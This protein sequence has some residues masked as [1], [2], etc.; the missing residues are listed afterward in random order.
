ME[1]L[2]TYDKFQGD[3]LARFLHKMAD[4]PEGEGSMLDNTIVY[5]GTSNSKTHV[6]KSYPLMVAGGRNLGIRQGVFHNMVKS[7]APLSNLL[8]TF[9]YL[10]DVPEK[11]FS[12][13]TGTMKEVLV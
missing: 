6:N 7:D 8:L 12:D 11:R 3:L 2:G 9:L 1:K 13:S 5:Y 10:L 4:T